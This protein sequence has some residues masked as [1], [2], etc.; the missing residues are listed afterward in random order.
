L[1]TSTAAMLAVPA[2]PLITP[3]AVSAISGLVSTRVMAPKPMM[4]IRM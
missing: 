2:P 1:A 4:K 3:L